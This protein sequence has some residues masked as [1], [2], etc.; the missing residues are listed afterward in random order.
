[1]GLLREGNLPH[2]Y[3]LFVNRLLGSCSS[4]TAEQSLPGRCSNV[5]HRFCS[6]Q[7]FVTLSIQ[8]HPRTYRSARVRVRNMVNDGLSARQITI[9]L[10]RFFTWWVNTTKVW[11]YSEL[12]AEFIDV[13]W[14]EE[15]AHFA[16]LLQIQHDINKCSN[17][18]KAVSS[19]AALAQDP[20]KP[21]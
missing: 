15:F 9:Y 11:K 14:D 7:K 16:K 4:T 17:Q 19:L 5:K 13:C 10:K 8:P 21:V 6:T 12:L 20:L 1:M 18:K 2:K 3:I